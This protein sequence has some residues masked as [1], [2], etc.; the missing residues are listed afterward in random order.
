[1][2][3]QVKINV[4]G[5]FS[6]DKVY[7]SGDPRFLGDGQTHNDPTTALLLARSGDACRQWSFK[8]FMLQV[9]LAF[10]HS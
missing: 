8:G 9:P 4:D 2:Q 6:T 3:N 10:H 5:A 1:M 7:W